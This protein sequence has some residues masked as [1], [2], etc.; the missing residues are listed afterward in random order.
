MCIRDRDEYGEKQPTLQWQ[1]A[2]N[3]GIEFT[4][5]GRYNPGSQSHSSLQRIA[6]NYT[7]GRLLRL[8][9]PALDRTAEAKPYSQVLLEQVDGFFIE[10][11]TKDGDWVLPQT[12]EDLPVGIRISLDINGWGR[13]TR[14][15]PFAVD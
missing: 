12:T 13:I 2:S 15:F 5:G 8:N 1:E 4:C 10:Y 6:Y 11:L 3:T 7:G 14:L 9:W